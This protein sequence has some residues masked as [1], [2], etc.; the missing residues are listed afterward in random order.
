M[1]AYFSLLSFSYHSA[2][3]KSGPGLPRTPRHDSASNKGPGSGG[4][5]A[6][7]HSRA[8]LLSRPETTSIPS[9]DGSPVASSILQ[10]NLLGHFKGFCITPISK[11]PATSAAVASTTTATASAILIPIRPAPPIAN[12]QR[13]QPVSPPKVP[14]VSIAYPTRSAPK[15]PPGNIGLAINN[16]NPVFSS[17]SVIN[18]LLPSRPDISSPVLDTTTSCA[19]KELIDTTNSK[20]IRTAPS[21][22]RPISTSIVHDVNIDPK[23]VKTN[24]DSSYPTLTRIA[25]F[26]RGQKGNQENK[27]D[28]KSGK[29]DKDTLRNL[30]ISNPI[31][32]KE[33]DV[34][35]SALPAGDK[36]VVM[37]AQ[38]LRNT[39]TEK[40]PPIPSFGSMRIPNSKRP[41]SI[42]VSGRPTS[43]PPPRPP[44]TIGVPG[45]QTPGKVD[46]MYDDCL[47]I[48]TEGTAPLVNIDEESPSSPADNIYAVI[49]ES[50]TDRRERKEIILPKKL[51]YTSPTG[52][53]KSPKAIES[54]VSAGSG[55]S[56]GLLGEIVSEIEARN[57]DSIYSTSTLKRKQQGDKYDDE[58]GSTVTDVSSEV[59]KN[60]TYVNT[61]WKPGYSNITGTSASSSSSSS[62]YL[63]PI[64]PN[65]GNKATEINSKPNES[66][67][68]EVKVPETSAPG[69]KPFIQR[70]MGPLISSFNNRK[71]TSES[72]GSVHNKTQLTRTKTPP[73]AQTSSENKL[74]NRNSPLTNSESNHQRH[75]NINNIRKDNE[76]LSL[77]KPDLVSSC[78]PS[79]VKSPDVLGGKDDVKSPSY[80]RKMIENK[81]AVAKPSTSFR[82]RQPIPAPKPAVIPNPSKPNSITNQPLPAIP[83]TA[84]ATKT[85]PITR[86]Q[87]EKTNTVKTVP[88]IAK[89]VNAN[90]SNVASLQQKFET[91]KQPL[92]SRSL[93]TRPPVGVKSNSTASD[94]NKNFNVKR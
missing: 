26:M 28:T 49:E 34:P 53:Y 19:A 51:E 80:G 68:T 78:S 86:A 67:R 1:Y 87:S 30:E 65:Q 93:S 11:T 6:S 64:N 29:I 74:S 37:R 73:G 44:S 18:N 52:D 76:S 69:Y 71:N 92:S 83:T 46:S 88:S 75:N 36:V 31:L 2:E 41:T 70:N 77:T 21:A 54:S 81:P 43:P 14:S 16:C 32:Q 12:T 40:R 39:S 5:V 3:K 23:Q 48:L 56:M 20:P 9:S 58:T 24:K 22:P 45:Y 7:D 42:P 91:N 35:S 38:S 82:G 89:Q 60:Q 27:K 47:N 25:S 62:G 59:D 33:I 85:K 90:K 66:S 79:A 4:M 10:N 72:P 8:L 13:N 55:E 61:S 57:T 50:P 15:P 63:S 84:S 94:S 17:S